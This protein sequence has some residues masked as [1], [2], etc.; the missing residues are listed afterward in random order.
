[1]ILVILGIGLG[2]ALL[3]WLWKVP[4]QKL[5]TSMVESGSHPAEAWFIVFFLFA[6]L[7]LA[8]YAIWRII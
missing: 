1:M 5:V 2:L 7:G 3:A 6:A 4:I 8:I